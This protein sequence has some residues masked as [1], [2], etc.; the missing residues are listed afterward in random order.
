MKD[1][2]FSIIFKTNFNDDQEKSLNLIDGKNSL[3]A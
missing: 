2:I 1:Y 3:V